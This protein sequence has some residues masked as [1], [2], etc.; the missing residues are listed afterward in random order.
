MKRAEKEATI[1]KLRPM[2]EGVQLY[3]TDCNGLTANQIYTLRKRLYEQ[4]IKCRVVPNGLLAIL[5]AN[6][7]YEALTKVLKQDSTLFFVK[8]NPSIP[9]KIIKKFKKEQD[10][11]KPLLKGA[12][13][14]EE[15]FIG[16]EQLQTL[17]TLK[18]KEDYIGEVIHL[19]Q[20][21]IHNVLAALDSAPSTIA[22]I[23]KT[24]QN[25]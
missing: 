24:L 9:A 6:T 18:S 20:S 19:L 13:V 23:I 17:S 25:K 11:K 2:F 7:P 4:E 5:F 8:G 22:G 3:I 15:I 12:W 10:V 16:D 14:A 21:P 1:A